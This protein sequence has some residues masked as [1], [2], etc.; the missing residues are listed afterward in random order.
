MKHYL[1]GKW[2]KILRKSAEYA[3]HLAGKVI[4]YYYKTSAS[5]FEKAIGKERYKALGEEIVK[6]SNPWNKLT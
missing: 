4:N 3:H 6:K 2:I 5:Y 1:R